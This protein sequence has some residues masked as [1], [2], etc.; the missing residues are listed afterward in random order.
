MSENEEKIVK[1]ICTSH[2]G[3]ACIF[4][5]HVKN[6]VITRIE[7]DNDEEPQYRACL[8]GRAYRQ[9]I[10]G[11]DRILYPLK[12]IGP[13]GSGEFKRISWDEAF[14]T[15]AKNYNMNKEHFGAGSVLLLASSGDGN[16]IHA[17]NTLYKL[18]SQAG[19]YT[20]TWA[21]YSFEQGNFAE[22]ATYG[23][24]FVRNDP[25]DLVNS[26]MIILWGCNPAVTIHRTKTAHFIKQAR[27]AGT[28]IVSIDPK[29]TRTSAI[30]ADQWIPIIPATDTAMLIAMAYV[31]IKERLQ[32]QEFLDKYTVGFDKFKKYVIGDEDGVPK[33]PEWAEKVCGVSASIIEN[34][35][36]EYATHK[37]AAFVC[38]ISPGRTAYGEQYHRAAITLSAITGNIG[39]HGGEVSSRTYPAAN[40]SLPP[41]WLD[42]PFPMPFPPN[43]VLER[44]PFQSHYIPDQRVIENYK[45]GINTHQ[46]AE[47]I[48]K[49]KSGGYP[50]DY[51]MIFIMTNNYLNQDCNTNKIVEAF[52][53]CFVVTLE[54]FMT[55]TAQ[56]SDIILPTAT[57]LERNNIM[58][59]N[60]G[61]PFLGFS[62]K[63]I[64]P[65][66]ESKSILDIAIGLA[67]K[68]G[69]ANFIDKTEEELLKLSYEMFKRQAPYFPDYE[70]FKKQGIVKVKEEEPFIQFK[71][72]IEDPENHPF[73]TPS[74][75]IEIYS[76][77]IA[78]LNRPEIPPI[79]KYIEAW[80][81]R[82]DPLIKKYPLQL[83]TTH[84][85]RRAHSQFDSLPWLRE[86]VKQE[87]LMNINDAKERGIITGDFVRIFNDR[88]EVIVTANVSERIMPG[89]VDL[90]EGAWFKPDKNGI[91]R[92]GCPNTLTLDR[93][94]PAGGIVTS[95]C[96]VQVEKANMDDRISEVN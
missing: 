2:C 79:P 28:K 54:Q 62:P 92:G 5:V 46:V 56:Y 67:E 86:L 10:Y 30:L 88:G 41:Y 48:L 31:I 63:I 91:D 59:T 94:S 13:K 6:G 69:V 7:T 25:A 71:Q 23:S 89:V 37:P 80:E 95:C 1:T 15:I 12:R 21:F 82:K 64:E 81:S 38:G 53:K 42:V 29:Y 34:L 9:R 40:C 55:S 17:P 90:P 78:D 27:E 83:L 22:I 73:P 96:L 57:L 33:T 3:G 24:M 77:R 76:K 18:F 8:R 52:K 65:L 44:Y 74:G 58:E 68:L 16:K 39:C 72:Q 51:K 66:G 19:G 61:G 47:A 4:K 60:L 35:A 36:R 43:P 70:E 11:K 49:G 87:L 75:K 20:S 84:I 26:K 85:I 32:D 14:E 50:F 93:T 45:A